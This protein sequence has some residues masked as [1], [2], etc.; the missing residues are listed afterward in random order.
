MSV[1]YYRIWQYPVKYIYNNFTVTE[2]VVMG[3]NL[4][5]SFT[6]APRR[7]CLISGYN[8]TWTQDDK[9]ENVVQYLLWL[10]QQPL[11][12]MIKSGKYYA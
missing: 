11:W 8:Y 9:Q 1:T 5:T 7:G 12:G 3:Q 2:R 10:Q 6:N 4:V